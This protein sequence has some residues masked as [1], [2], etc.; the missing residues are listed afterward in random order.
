MRNIIFAFFIGA[1]LSFGAEIQVIDTS[2]AAPQKS[3]SI[4]YEERVSVGPYLELSSLDSKTI[5][6]D[7]KIM[8]R[9]YDIKLNSSNFYGFSGN[10]PLNNWIG[11]YALG[12]YQYV[13][14]KYKDKDV[15]K[16]YQNLASIIEEDP[17]FSLDSSAVEGHFDI[18][19]ISVQLGFEAGVPILSSYNYQSMLKLF[20]FLGGVGGRAF[21]RNTDFMNAA[22]WGYAWGIG[23]RGAYEKLSVSLG[24][25][26]SH[27]YSRTYF[28]K[29]S[30]LDKK[31]DTFMIDAD[32][33]AQLFVSASISL[34]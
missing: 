27:L 2:M 3:N 21:Y 6:Y 16:G 4:K 12:G 8:N 19:R 25:R 33:S 24:F 29:P 30:L 20:T 15:E 34:F 7:F 17:S 9:P 1:T 28:E 18:H 10:L 23:I 22:H 11:L 26:S 14:V 32:N 5:T 13:E 31:G